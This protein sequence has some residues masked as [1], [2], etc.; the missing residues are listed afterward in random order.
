MC[1]F[2]K[3]ERDIVVQL[4]PNIQDPRPLTQDPKYVETYLIHAL[5]M[6]K[7]GKQTR[8]RSS[9]PRQRPN[10]KILQF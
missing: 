8:L 6:T 2:I 10:N 3:N 5:N 9:S 7:K 1:Y 4:R